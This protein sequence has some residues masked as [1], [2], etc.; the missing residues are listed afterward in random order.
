MRVDRSTLS[1]RDPATQ[2]RALVNLLLRV[3]HTKHA[4]EIEPSFVNITRLNSHAATSPKSLLGSWIALFLKRLKRDQRDDVWRGY[5]QTPLQNVHPKTM[6]DFMLCHE[7]N[8]LMEK[9][10]KA[11]TS[12]VQAIRSMRV[13][14]TKLPLPDF[15]VIYNF[16]VQ[17]NEVCQAAH[18]SLRLHVEEHGC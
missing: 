4:F 11:A 10:E 12:Y 3:A 1:G 5:S 2:F 17:A 13:Y 18:Q 9:Y 7:K 8:S 15:E 16:A 6:G 14:A